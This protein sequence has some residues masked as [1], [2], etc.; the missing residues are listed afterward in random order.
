MNL[1]SCD[2]TFSG[3]NHHAWREFGD[4]RKRDGKEEIL[5]Q[6]GRALVQAKEQIVKKGA[7]C[8]KNLRAY[9]EQVFRN[10]VIKALY[11]DYGRTPEDP[12]IKKEHG[13]KLYRR[14]IILQR[15][16]EDED[17]RFQGELAK[18]FHKEFAKV[19]TLELLRKIPQALRGI[20]LD[21]FFV[22]LSQEEVAQ[23]HGLT[24]RTIRSKEAQI[25]KKIGIPKKKK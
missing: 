10:N 5:S 16:Q 13:R 25:R 7:L 18:P 15:L 23:K 24:G 21:R 11:Q 6:A 12:D 14:K 20:A 17:F 1:D 3:W 2:F 4:L 22:G 9:I 19:I 8:I